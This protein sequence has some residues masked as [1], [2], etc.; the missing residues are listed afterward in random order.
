D[1]ETRTLLVFLAIPIPG[2]LDA[3]TPVFVGMDFLARWA[4]DQRRL[5]S[6]RQ[7]SRGRQWRSRN[8]RCGNATKTVAIEGLAFH[9]RTDGEMCLVDGFMAHLGEEVTRILQLR[10]RMFRQRE[11]VAWRSEEHTSELQSR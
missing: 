2:K 10:D 5:R 11:T 7:R 1:L 8:T 4:D 6:P 9:A 3:D